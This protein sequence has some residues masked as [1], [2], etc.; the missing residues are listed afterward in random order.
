MVFFSSALLSGS[1]PRGL[2]VAVGLSLAMPGTTAQAQ[3]AATS[4]AS[5]G[6]WTGCWVSSPARQPTASDDG[7]LLP[8]MQERPIGARG[9]EL[10][11]RPPVDPATEMIRCVSQDGE[12][13]LHV[14]E[15]S[16]TQLLAT[17]TLATLPTQDVVLSPA[18]ANGASAPLTM[19]PAPATAG[20]CSERGVYRLVAPGLLSYTIALQCGSLGEGRRDG[21]WT[22]AGVE[23]IQELERADLGGRE[24]LT[25]AR[26][27]QR[28]PQGLWPVELQAQVDA[29]ALPLLGAQQPVPSP[30][31]PLVEQLVGITGPD[32]TALW[33]LSRG[34]GLDL[35]SRQLAALE[36]RG[37]ATPVIDALIAL[38]H[39]DEFALGLAPEAMASRERVLLQRRDVRRDM[40]PWGWG[41]VPVGPWGWSPFWDP[42][43]SPWGP[44]WGGGWGWN[45]WGPGWIPGRGVRIVHRR[46]FFP[47]GGGWQ[48]GG[49]GNPGSS[50]G[51][52]R[53]GGRVDPDRGYQPPPSSGSGSGSRPPSSSGSSDGGSG[54]GSSSGGAS[55]G[56]RPAVSR[57]PG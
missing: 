29:R 46:P 56:R 44:A 11:S 14:R 43:W 12:G 42:F 27:L 13:R 18:S 45:A 23:T 16:R 25:R 31:L 48:G 7:D 24:P 39:P 19:P 35:T 3:G 57:P 22:L 10:E 8:R 2:L 33:L 28:A 30:T 53:G 26:Q 9:R 1:V 52:R 38:D 36:Q 21:L 40:D 5:V 34:E 17:P 54:S 41:P 4:L 51:V 6:V 32:L 20:R 55:S 49:Q 50:G 47:G 15:F 37:V